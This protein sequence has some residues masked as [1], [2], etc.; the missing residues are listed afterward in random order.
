MDTH[1][2]VRTALTGHQVISTLHAGSCRGV[3]ERLFVMVPDRSAVL[4]ATALVLNQRLLRR[5]CAMCGGAGCDACLRTG[6]RGRTPI[7]EYVKLTE[8]LREEVAARGPSAILP[9]GNDLRERALAFAEQK[10]TL[11][12]EIQ[13][14]L[15]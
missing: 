7:A 8:T 6:F 11:P 13:R 12:T 14:V 4:A 3:F 15:G 2:A 5:V 9:V 1:F 10:L